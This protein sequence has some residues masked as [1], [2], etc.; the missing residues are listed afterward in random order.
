MGLVYDPIRG[1]L[2]RSSTA[3]G[4]GPSPGGNYSVEKFTLTA[5]NITDKYVVLAA[6]PS[7]Q[8]ATRLIVI[9]GIEQDYAVDFEMTAD[10]GGQRLSWDGLGLE[11]LL[12]A[13]DKIVVVYT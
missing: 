6:A 11:S 10:D 3:S 4:G 13:G 8:S 7:T 9:E 5:G 1:G 2:V 12:E